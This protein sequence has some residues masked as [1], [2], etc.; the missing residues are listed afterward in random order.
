MTNLDSS[1]CVSSSINFFNSQQWL[2]LSSSSNWNIPKFG[3]IKPKATWSYVMKT[4]SI[5]TTYMSTT[6]ILKGRLI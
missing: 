3:S 5:I 2:T 1:G 6:Y 4:Y